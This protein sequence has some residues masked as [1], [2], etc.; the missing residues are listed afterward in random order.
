MLPSASRGA[1]SSPSS[2]VSRPDRP[3]KCS[4]SAPPPMPPDCGST[5]LSTSC[6]AIMASIAVPFSAS[7]S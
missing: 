3:S 7:T 4:S 2:E 5:R 1:V 6:T